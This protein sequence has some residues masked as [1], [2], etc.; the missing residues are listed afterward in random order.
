MI[1]TLDPAN[2][3]THG[4]LMRPPQGPDHPMWTMVVDIGGLAVRGLSIDD[5][6]MHAVGACGVSRTDTITRAAGEAVER[7]ALFPGDEAGPRAITATAV[8]LDSAGLD[9]AGSGLGDPH[10]LDR[11]LRWY[12]GSRLD[13]Q[14]P[15]WVPSGLVDYPLADPWFDPTP[16]GAASG[17]DLRFA[18]RGALLELI[19]RD[20][21]G[22]A[23]AAESPLQEIDVEAEIA[24][25][26]SHPNWRD[27]ARL[28][29]WAREQDLRPTLVRVPVL[30]GLHCVLAAVIDGPDL[31]AVGAKAHEDL[32][33][34]LLIALQE[35]VQVRD[36]LTALR[37]QWGPTAAPDAVRDDVDR[38]R[39]WLTEAAVAELERRLHDLPAASPG[40][41]S[42][43]PRTPAELV[44]AILADGG[45]PAM[46]DLTTRLPETHRAMGWRAVKVV[47]P[48]Y[49]PLRMDERHQFGWQHERIEA[50]RT[51]P[52]RPFPHPLI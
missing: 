35:A 47:I 31:A 5:Y 4:W 18:V 30:P 19:E 9:F 2:G 7:F 42:S 36:V 46:V 14:Q 3:L 24:L 6:P 12:Q 52:T 51:K 28:Y 8:E 15:V 49:Q 10:A 16:S 23:W 22:V 50:A 33:R 39:L 21:V 44:A 13:C 11:P 43:P 26:R 45:R 38:A 25:A 40:P 17:P 27:L 20:A 48:G 29:R 32:G 41:P 37:G 1:Q 34:A